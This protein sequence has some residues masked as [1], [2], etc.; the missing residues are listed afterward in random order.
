[1]LEDLR[2]DGMRGPAA[3][4][5]LRFGGNEQV[6]LLERSAGNLPSGHLDG[7]RAGVQAE[8]LR[9]GKLAS[10]GGGQLAAP[11]A[12]VE[13]TLRTAQERQ[14]EAAAVLLGGIPLVRLGIFRPVAIP[15]VASAGRGVSHRRGRRRRC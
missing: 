2:S 10:D 9:A 7:S 12:D 11:T 5:R 6:A 1:M 3:E 4:T 13:N 8:D 15:V 14:H